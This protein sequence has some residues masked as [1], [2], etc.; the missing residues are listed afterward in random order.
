MELQFLGRGS[1]FNAAQGN[2]AACLREGER[3][4][5][6]DC[7]ETVFRELTARGLLKGAREVTVAISH[8]HSDHCGSLG[9]L[10]HYCRYALGAQLRVVVPD[11]EAY[12]GDLRTL[13]HFFGSEEGK[14]YRFVSAGPLGFA[15]F[16]RLDFVPTRH[17]E[18]M[19]CYSFVLE[20]ASG[21]VFYSADTCTEEPFLEFL[22][23]H[24]A[25]ECAY[26]DV[27]GTDS[28]NGVHLPLSRLA[29]VTPEALRGR[30][31]LMHVNDDAC[32]ARGE[33]LGF[34][35]VQV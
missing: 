32:I 13:L 8:L 18:G 25:F 23:T 19:Q 11:C 30:V 24:P 3:L 9:T 6:L 16:E 34:R 29:E 35:C 20:T 7:G 5:L 1:A 10:S 27:T 2:T 14:A 15:A 26:M 21:G 22:R 4:L 12:K 28:T 17:A 33:Q 31:C